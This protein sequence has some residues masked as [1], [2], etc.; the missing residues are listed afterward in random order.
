MVREPLILTSTYQDFA[1]IAREIAKEPPLSPNEVA[2]RAEDLLRERFTTSF[3]EILDE[4]PE[5]VLSM[6][7]KISGRS[8]R[9]R[10]E[11]RRQILLS[12]AKA[13][14][15]PRSRRAVY[16]WYVDAGVP[17]VPRL[18]QAFYRAMLKVGGLDQIAKQ[19]NQGVS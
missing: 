5:T 4:S 14:R 11:L 16:L 9:T 10:P 3:A 17:D 7:A 8:D 12:L 15:E 13:A 6:L 18:D 1:S 19:A 2:A